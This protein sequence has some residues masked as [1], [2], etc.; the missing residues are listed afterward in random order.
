MSHM[1]KPIIDEMAHATR[2]VGG[3]SEAYIGS[4]H[5]MLSG[6]YLRHSLTQVKHSEMGVTWMSSPNPNYCRLC[7]PGGGGVGGVIKNLGKKLWWTIKTGK[8]KIY[9]MPSIFLGRLLLSEK[10]AHVI[11]N[12][13]LTNATITP[14]EE[15]KF[16]FY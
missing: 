6:V 1:E 10:A 13:S 9:F 14:C 8:A 3:R 12:H 5:I 4:P 11:V 15:A 7:G 16:S 2:N